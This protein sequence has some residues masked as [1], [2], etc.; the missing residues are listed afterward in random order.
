MNKSLKIGLLAAV[1]GIS[2]CQVDVQSTTT[3]TESAAPLEAD[4]S[5]IKAHL[6]FLAHDLLE[7]RDTGS[8][9]HELATLYIASQFEQY[10]LTPM[11]DDDSYMQRVTFRQAFLDQ[12]SPTLTLTR[13]GQ[14]QSL[15]YPAQYITGPSTLYTDA[16]VSAEM[17]FVGY[18]IVAPEL[19]H[20]D[21]EGLDVDG[22]VVVMLSGKPA[23]FPTEEGAHFSSGAEKSRH[24]EENGAI[25]I[26]TV[27]TPTAEKARPYQNQLNFLHAPRVRWVGKDG[28]PA[29]VYPNLKNSAYFSQKA[30]EI[31]FEGSERS[32]E[33][34]YKDLEA[35]KSPKG[36]DLAYTLDFSKKSTHKE[37][38]SPNVV[39]ML[40]GSDPVL[41]NEYVVYSAHSDHIGL[42]KTVKKDKINNGAMDNASGT[43]IM[44]ETAR[45]FSEL[46]N[47]PKRS[48]LFVAVTGEEK[49]LLGADYYARNPTVGEGKM[50]ANVNLDMPL[51]THDFADLIAFGANHS[52]LKGSVQEAVTQVGLELAEDPWPELNLFTRSDHYSFVKQ[53]VPA[54]FLFPGLKSNS[55]DI[56]GSK[57]FSRFMAAHYHKPSDELNDDFNWNAAKNFA[58]INFQIGLTIGNQAEKPKW[59]E[60]S[61]F[62]NTFGK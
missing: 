17:V 47:R 29:N 45:L 43:S 42:A 23:S 22:K 10:G 31:L 48:M 32:L 44:I 25:G 40:E 26:I 5:R 3:S 56:D 51:I 60:D 1:V 46:E 2:A 33:E 37:I 11:G 54:V 39:G 18:G 9:G 12:D 8:R 19:S 36:F 6:G 50:V 53:G 61:F 55:T 62:G 20:N 24:A 30:A 13:D 35:D 14:T 21:Y 52:D 49:G 16:S 59:N 58:Q 28:Q 57:E 15:D 38:T 41:K 4:S 7:G 34:I 27:S